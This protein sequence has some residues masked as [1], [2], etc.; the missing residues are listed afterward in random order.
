MSRSFGFTPDNGSV[1][2]L[3][4]QG[5]A[6]LSRKAIFSKANSQIHKDKDM[7]LRFAQPGHGVLVLIDVHTDEIGFPRYDNPTGYTIVGPGMN[8]VDSLATNKL[9]EEEFGKLEPPSDGFLRSDEERFYAWIPPGGV[10]EYIEW[11]ASIRLE[12]DA[13][14]AV[15]RA[16]AAAEAIQKALDIAD[17][18]KA[19]QAIM[20]AATPRQA[21]EDAGA[22]VS[23]IRRSTTALEQLRIQSQASAAATA[24][25]SRY[26]N[27]T[28]NRQ[29]FQSRERQKFMDSQ[30]GTFGGPRIPTPPPNQP[31]PS[32][33]MNPILP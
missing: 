29:V 6:G 1:A 14:T 24:E 22:A 30:V 3:W 20:S 21:L 18:A 28:L 17:G 32:M 2:D 9:R 15:T 26:V 13:E 12:Q 4:V 10:P 27:E 5:F 23:A 19:L 8:A 7:L 11:P 25:F 31:D 16:K 33:T